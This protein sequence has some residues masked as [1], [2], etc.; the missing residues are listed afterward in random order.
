MIQCSTNSTEESHCQGQWLPAA[1]LLLILKLAPWP[2]FVAASRPKPVRLGCAQPWL[3][4][5]PFILDLG[6]LGGRKWLLQ[7]SPAPKHWKPLGP[8]K[9]VIAEQVKLH[10]VEPGMSD[11]ELTGRTGLSKVM[12]IEIESASTSCCL[13]ILH[14]L[15]HSLSTRLQHC[16]DVRILRV[17]PPLTR[18]GGGSVTVRSG[19]RHGGEYRSLLRSSDGTGP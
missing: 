1:G 17:R 15:A 7:P 16:S 19:T 4:G 5:C 18:E 12:I 14:R 9:G 8:L 11:A 10:R 3:M 6:R 13:T 2:D